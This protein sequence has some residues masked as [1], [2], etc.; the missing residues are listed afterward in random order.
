MR[1]LLD[2][3]GYLRKFAEDCEKVGTFFG[4]CSEKVGGLFGNFRSCPEAVSNKPRRRAD[5]MSHPEIALQVR[6]LIVD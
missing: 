2:F 5:R 1:R 6:G 4:T 3:A